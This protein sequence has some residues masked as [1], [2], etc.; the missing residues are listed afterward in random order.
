MSLLVM[1]ISNGRTKLALACGGELVTE[2]RVLP[3][4]ELAAATLHDVCGSWEYMRVVLSSVV[5]EA[6]AA[7]TAS[8]AGKVPVLRVR[9]TDDLPVDF[10]SYAGRAT[11]GDDRIANA[12]AAVCARPSEALVILDAGTATTIDV[13]L[14]A[15]EG[16]KKPS[17]LGGAIAPGL[18]TMVQALHRG[19]AQLPAVPLALPEHAIGQGTVEAIQNGCVRGYRGLLRELLREMEHACGCCLHPVLTGGDAP[20]LADLMPELGAPEPQ[21]TLRGVARWAMG[22]EKC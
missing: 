22:S 14:P 13:V 9:P 12:I 18:G 17:F 5:P 11:L 6:A 8:F 16:K 21:L 4:A 3:T 19:T 1:D 15:C 20:L 7:V 2:V 10:C